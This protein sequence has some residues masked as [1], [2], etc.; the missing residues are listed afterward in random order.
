MTIYGL[1]S[2]GLNSMDFAVAPPPP[3]FIASERASKLSSA[4]SSTL[5]F[6]IWKRVNADQN[7]SKKFLRHPLYLIHFHNWKFRRFQFFSFLGRKKKANN[8]LLSCRNGEQR[9]REK[10]FK[11]KQSLLPQNL[12]G[13]R[14][15]ERFHSNFLTHLSK[16]FGPLCLVHLFCHF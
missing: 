9:E 16:K 13:S 14:V 10:S 5:C 3:M 4:H 6:F 15:C 11:W 2:C 12:K 8:N 1:E 7:L